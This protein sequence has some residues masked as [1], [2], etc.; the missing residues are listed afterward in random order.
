[1]P[2]AL[3]LTVG[4]ILDRFWVVPLVASLGAGVVCMAAWF[5]FANTPK[6]WLALLYLWGC[7]AAF[8]ASYHHWQRYHVDTSDLNRFAD[9]DGKPTR[10]RGTLHSAPIA[11]A[12]QR[13]P[14]RSFPTKDATR[15]I[16]RATH[17]QDLATRTW[18]E[19]TGLV[20]VTLVGRTDDITVGDE[21]ELLGRLALPDDAANP[22]GFD[23]ASFLRDQGVTTLLTVLETD[24][25]TLVRRG[26][27]TSVFGVLAMVRGWGQRTLARDFTVQHEVAS[28]L[29]LGEGA[30]MT[31]E[32]WDR[33][34]RTGV[35][36]VLAISGQHLVVLAGFLWLASWLLG[37]RRR[38]AAPT[39]AIFLIAYALLTGGR[40]PAMRAAWVVAVYCGGILLQRPVAHANTFALAWIGVIA[41]NPSD[42][43]NAGC[44]LS[45]LA[46]AML[47]WGVSRWT[48]AP[49]DPLERVLDEAR[50]WHGR[51]VR[52]LVRWVLLLYAI[53]A[54]VWLA[55]APLV[56]AHFHLFSPVAL[57]IGPPVTLLTSLA[58]LTGF[59]FLLLSWCWPLAWVFGWVTQ[60]SLLGCEWLV[61]FGLKLPGAYFFVADVPV[62]WLWLFYVPLLV[63]LTTPIPWRVSRWLL[64]VGCAWLLLGAL[65][66][67]LP[68]RS[69]EFRCTFVAVGH[70]GCTVIETPGGQ[71][72]VYDAGATG[73]P[74][75]TRRHIAPFLWSRGIRRIDALI[76]SHADLDH[77]NGVPQ[78]AERFTIERVICTPTFAER[79]LPAVQKTVAALERRGIEMQ[80]VHAGMR[81]ETDGVAFA[82]LHPPPIG[83]AGKE[84]VRSLVLHV[85][86]RDFSMLLTGDLEEAG[87]K[88]VLAQAAPRIDVL[89]A[90]HHGSDTSNVPDLA[91]WAKP[92][93][94]VS[95]Q[96]APLSERQSVKMYE[97]TGARFLGTWPH[98][99]ITIRPDDR[100]AP[101]QTH[102]TKL[103]IRV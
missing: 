102:R 4:I 62:W 69:G 41:I 98:G 7:V 28:A 3:A 74:D 53:N 6:K 33:Y 37:V 78:L 22:G 81:W 51:V 65:L 13:D 50:P 15:F 85:T 100:E 42:I 52:W 21:V 34:Q 75:V 95:C 30:D 94:V 35:L 58:L 72:F 55:V 32:D 70:G 17:R 91:K 92:K 84:N 46:V 88:Q 39:I 40:P 77:F 99:A 26:W 82:V 86:Y 16:L 25:V 103:K 76:L 19:V 36:H 101:V 60:G 12:G 29:L 73:G 48:D 31:G 18:S 61:A 96:T 43:F 24:E 9:H 5:L 79:S 45:F 87:L 67:V 71:V 80:I 93:L 11:Q 83:P 57:I 10:L 89:M 64:V 20:Q 59:A 38:T 90:P 1:M 44:Q 66:Q 54:M 97:K 56:A 23:Y 63:G 68:H 27:P 49:S 2:V 8:G 14:L 47:V